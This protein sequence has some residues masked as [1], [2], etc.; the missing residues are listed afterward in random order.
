MLPDQKQ[1][2]AKYWETL[3]QQQLSLLRQ[4]ATVETEHAQ[5][6]LIKEIIRLSEKAIADQIYETES[7]RKKLAKIGLTLLHIGEHAH[8]LLVI[9]QHLL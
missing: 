5:Q 4:L 8:F 7:G 2:N 9:L 3:A 1:K 6:L